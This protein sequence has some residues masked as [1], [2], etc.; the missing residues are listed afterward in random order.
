VVLRFVAR[1]ASDLLAKKT[2]KGRARNGFF[3]ASTF[4]MRGGARA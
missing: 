4:D 1:H 2:R 3:T